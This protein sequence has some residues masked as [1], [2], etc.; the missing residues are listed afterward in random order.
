ME[1]TFTVNV[2]DDLWVDS[3]TENKTTDYTYN[4]PE[5]INVIVSL[6]NDFQ[7]ITWSAEEID[8]PINEETEQL[9]QI[10]AN[11]DTSI[12]HALV[13]AADEWEYTYTTITNHDGSTHEEINNPSLNDIYEVT[14]TPA[15]G[16]NLSLITKELETMN[17]KAAKD[18]LDYVVKYDDAYD[19]DTDTQA[20]ID[21]FKTN[22]ESYLTT[23]TTVYPWRYVTID[24]NEI[25]KIPATLV[26]V[27]NN[28]PKID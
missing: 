16:F 10:D 17:E 4:G 9:I 25:P 5:T 11:I 3:W 24:K 28:L 20:I 7:I 2:P 22:V 27:F 14:W 6:K 1:K 12:A 18:R 8:R 21:A 19:F 13:H 26:S 15:G 23:M